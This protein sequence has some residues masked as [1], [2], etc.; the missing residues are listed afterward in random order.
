MSSKLSRLLN[1]NGSV[2]IGGFNLKLPGF[3]GGLD[4]VP[5]DDFVARLHKG[6][7]VLT[8]EEN[9]AYTSAEENVKTN[10]NVTNNMYGSN[11]DYAKMAN[12]FLSALNKCKL[13][14]D[15]DGMARFVQN[16]VYKV[17]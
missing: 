4:Y 12:A 6:E 16:E 8:K 2:K 1:I 14:L 13:S 15:E 7:R 3:K 11:I 10:H 5:K 9:E 17:V